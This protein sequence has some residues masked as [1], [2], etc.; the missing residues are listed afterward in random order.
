[1]GQLNTV[2]I[3][4]QHREG[5]IQYIKRKHSIHPDMLDQINFKNLQNYLNYQ[6]IHR[7]ASMVKIIQ[8]CFLNI[9]FFKNNTNLRHVYANIVD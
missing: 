2:I 1:M 8:K 3:G 6:R 7:R 4:K 9:F 5:L